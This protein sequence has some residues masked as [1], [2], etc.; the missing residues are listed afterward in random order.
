M[1]IATTTVI[2][3]AELASLFF[4]KLERFFS[5]CKQVFTDLRKRMT[6]EHLDMVMMLKINRSYW[7][8]KTYAQYKHEFETQA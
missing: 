5:G 4:V 3:D 8:L 2:K 1:E 7:D 6:H